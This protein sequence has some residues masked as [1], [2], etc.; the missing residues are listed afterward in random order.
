MWKFP[1][2]FAEVDE[3]GKPYCF[4]TFEIADEEGKNKAIV[5]KSFKKDKAPFLSI[6]KNGIISLI[7]MLN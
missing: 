7:L 5:L 4:S 1:E 2:N 3:E 6:P